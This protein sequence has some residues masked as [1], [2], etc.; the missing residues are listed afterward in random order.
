[1]LFSCLLAVP[2]LI[3]AGCESSSEVMINDDADNT[4]D[5]TDTTNLT[6]DDAY[7]NRR[8]V[9][10]DLVVYLMEA[11]DE[12][13]ALAE[14]LERNVASIPAASAEIYSS[15]LIALEDGLNAFSI[16]H[17]ELTRAETESEWVALWN[18]FQA[19]IESYIDDVASVQMSVDAEIGE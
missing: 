10:A 7:T 6:G 14:T 4:T 5:T 9:E 8:A 12:F 15:S 19:D 18:S 17:D 13:V 1:M 2:L 3:G 11:E 16:R